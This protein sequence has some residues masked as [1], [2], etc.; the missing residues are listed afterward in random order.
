MVSVYEP[1]TQSICAVDEH[2]AIVE[3]LRA[4]DVARAIEVSREHFLHVESRL[5]LD[6]DAAPVS[7]DLT[8]VF[9]AVKPKPRKHWMLRCARNDGDGPLAPSRQHLHPAERRH[10]SLPQHHD[11]R[12]ELAQFGDVVADI[13]HGDIG[14][15]PQPHQIRQN[16]ELAG[17]VERAERLVE[18]QQARL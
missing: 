9:A 5:H 14:L 1:A 13:D 17:F 7:E 2:G 12:R 11:L 16:L 3:A 4:R 8:A 10:P 15:V 18:Q 6:D